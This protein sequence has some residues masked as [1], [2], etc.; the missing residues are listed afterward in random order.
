MLKVQAQIR[1]KLFFPFY[2]RC[3]NAKM[4]VWRIERLADVKN[5]AAEQGSSRDFQECTA[6]ILPLDGTLCSAVCSALSSTQLLK[7]LQ[8]S[9]DAQVTLKW[10]A[11]CKD[12]GE[13]RCAWEGRKGFPF[14]SSPRPHVKSQELLLIHPVVWNYSAPAPSQ[15]K[16]IGLPSGESK[17]FFCLWLIDCCQPEKVR[18]EYVLLSLRFYRLV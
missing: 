13:R 10:S 17:F 4:L 2:A 8:A 1:Q 6:G 18:L 14:C 11:K 12:R 16:S 3:L 9:K 7:L 5:W 15:S